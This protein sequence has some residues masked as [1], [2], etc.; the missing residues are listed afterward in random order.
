MSIPVF[1]DFRRLGQGFSSH[2]S[3]RSSTLIASH[4][5]GREVRV[6]LYAQP[7]YDFEL[8]FNALASNGQYVGIGR[9]TLQLLMGFFNDLGGSFGTFLFTDRT[10]NG[11]KGIPLSPV[12]NGSNTTF[13]FQRALRSVFEPVGYVSYISAVYWNGV[14]QVGNW[15]LANPTAAVP[16]P[17]LTFTSAPAANVV[18]SADFNWQFVC[19]SSDDTLDFEEFMS[20]LWTL[21]S[22]KFQSVRNGGF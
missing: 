17:N 14:A 18:V 6:P 19:R 11:G 20:N 9:D 3:P 1:P 7:L 10:D 12:G 8:T 4:A 2:K 15:A 16:Y 22:W 5:S 21:K 13:T